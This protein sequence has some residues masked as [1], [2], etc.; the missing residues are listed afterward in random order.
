MKSEQSTSQYEA[1]VCQY[2]INVSFPRFYNKKNISKTMKKK[3][4]KRKKKRKK[5]ILRRVC[6]RMKQE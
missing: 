6:N 1:S 4:K 3:R 2:R 5:S